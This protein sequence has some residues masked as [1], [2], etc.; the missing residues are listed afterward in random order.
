MEQ[1][2]MS[3]YGTFTPE[4]WTMVKSAPMIAA[5]LVVVAD[6]SG[7]IDTIREVMAAA[8]AVAAKNSA[9][10]PSG[11]VSAVL[12]D[13][14]ADAEQAKAEKL[15]AI[16]F[17][18]QQMPQLPQFKSAAEMT[19]WLA[20]SLT[21]TVAFVSQKSPEDLASFRQWVMDCAVAT[22]NA[23]KEGSFLGIGGAVVSES[24][25]A[26]LDRIKTIL[27]L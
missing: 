4:E 22:A 24:E 2:V 20:A 14:E 6:P 8:R 7:P 1:Q 17:A 9:Y 16:D 3:P 23:A 18:K 10:A 12:T 21:E 27:G 5:N 11:L 13:W 15:S 19:D 26:A 25:H